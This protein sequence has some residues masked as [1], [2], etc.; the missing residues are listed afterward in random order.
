MV[1]FELSPYLGHGFRLY[2]NKVLL[3]VRKGMICEL[4]T[5]LLAKFVISATDFELPLRTNSHE[6]FVVLSA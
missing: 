4:G 2:T 3:L 5:V 1:K 6:I